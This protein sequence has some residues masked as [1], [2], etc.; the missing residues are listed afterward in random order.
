MIKIRLS[1]M[2][3]IQYAIWGAWAPILGL[4]LGNLGLTGLQIGAVYSTLPLAVMISSFVG[5]QIADRWLP[6]QIFLGLCHLAGAGALWQA[7]AARD[8]GGMY[9]WMFLWS[10]AFAPTLSLTNSI[11]FVHLGDSDKEFPLIR[12][13]GTIGWIAAGMGLTAW[14]SGLG[15]SIEGRIDSLAMA[16]VFSLA[17]GLGSFFLPSTPPAS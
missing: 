7:S 17:L 15:T 4:D 14:R 13:L 11:C 1:I 6:T 10:L 16:A 8:F 12:T 3:F 9:M 2:M 5:G